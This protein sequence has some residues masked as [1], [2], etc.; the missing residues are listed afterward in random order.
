MKHI[1]KKWLWLFVLAIVLTVTAV[2]FYYYASQPNLVESEDNYRVTDRGATE[3]SEI[4]K[5]GKNIV[6]SLKVTN[7]SEQY[8]G[9]SSQRVML[10][11]KEKAKWYDVPDMNMK[12]EDSVFDVAPGNEKTF[13]FR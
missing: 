2:A 1:S 12:W 5:E 4:I 10:E 3:V 8:L 6:V 13:L 7:E 9:Y 11:R